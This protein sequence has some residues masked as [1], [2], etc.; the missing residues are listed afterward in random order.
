MV[1]IL[2]PSAGS[3]S[4][5]KILKDVDPDARGQIAQACIGRRVPAGH[6]FVRHA[7]ETDDLYFIV[8]G[9][10]RATIYSRGGR[11]VTFRDLSSG[12]TFGELSAIDSA[13]R[14]ASVVASVES[15]ILTISGEAFRDILVRFPSV[16]MVVMREL[17]ALVR[18]LS[19]RVVEFSTLGV[20][21]RI[22]AELLRLAR[23]HDSEGGGAVIKPS[24]THA[25]IASR[26]SCNRE[27]VTREFNRLKSSNVIEP[28]GRT[29]IIPN[30]ARLE[31]MVADVQGN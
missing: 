29:L 23:E 2:E 13:P 16:A 12:E 25:D 14:S 10:V 9:R 27:A 21:N 30:L 26:I 6:E 4:G 20:N 3:L 15:T 22:H 1:T 7:E 31:R 19:D 8:S 18:L 17:T 11:E 28:S 24:P 5:I